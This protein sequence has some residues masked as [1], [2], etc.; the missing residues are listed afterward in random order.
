[1][2][3][4]S[5]TISYQK[6]AV[7]GDAPRSIS[8]DLLE[9]LEEFALQPRESRSAEEVEYGWC[10]LR[11]VL[12]GVFTHENNVY[13]DCL[14]FAFR[15]D[16]NRVPAELR[17]AYEMLE[18]EASLAESASRSGEAAVGH[19]GRRGR[20]TARQN[21][22]ARIE[23]ETRS[24]RFRR[25]KLRQVLWDVTTG[26]LY[27]PVSP[28]TQPMLT[29]LFERTFGL[30]L[31]PL[32]AGAA[33]LRKLESRGHR[34]DYEDLRPSRFV[35]CADSEG[36]W[37][38]YP[39]VGMGQGPKDYLGNEFLLWLIEGSE[40]GD[41]TV[42]MGSNGSAREVSLLWERTLDLD[43]AYGQTGRAVLRGACPVRMPEAGEA[44]RA[45]KVPRRAFLTL[46]LS[47]DV[48][49]FSLS[50]ETLAVS[51]LKL[52]EIQGAASRRQLFEERITHLREFS[53]TMDRL[54]E[55]FLAQRAG[56]GWETRCGRI[57][58][59]IRGGTT[60]RAIGSA[61]AIG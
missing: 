47:G 19:L 39:W 41:G 52:P 9:K 30:E 24:G 10:G 15:V 6:F 25:S 20:Q 43:C 57:G 7:T 34:R 35:H 50:A 17:R 56:S 36:A 4:D 32:S 45:G 26:F 22:K 44:F 59:W 2:A 23:E 3:F 46:E 55:A 28:G 5:G 60:R 53:G 58:R 61:E 31:V 18:E 11:H 37:P 29:E 13:N 48:Y 49:S 12:D 1:M 8:E 27:C 38:D 14:A 16:T 42:K 54:L 33:A 51:G 40:S 21:A